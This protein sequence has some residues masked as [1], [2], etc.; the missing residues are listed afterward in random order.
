M[1]GQHVFYIGISYTGWVSRHG[2]INVSYNS[3]IAYSQ[4]YYIEGIFNY[5]LMYQDHLLELFCKYFFFFT[6][7]GN[8]IIYKLLGSSTQI[9][10][11]YIYSYKMSYNVMLLKHL[12]NVLYL[13]IVIFRCFQ[14]I[15]VVVIV[16]KA[17]G[18]KSSVSKYVQLR[19]LRS[20]LWSSCIRHIK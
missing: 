7:N 11:A 18:Y 16:Y 19:K 5:N 4:Y 17:V 13:K 6:L 9:K 20:L 1:E 2:I 15:I 8:K 12:N 10:K 14:W 3:R